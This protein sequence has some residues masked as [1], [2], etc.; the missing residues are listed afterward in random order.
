M[1]FE[2][3]SI[4][5]E[6]RIKRTIEIYIFTLLVLGRLFICSICLWLSSNSFN[7]CTHLFAISSMSSVSET[8]SAQYLHR[9][10]ASSPTLTDR[11]ITNSEINDT[12]NSTVG[13][14]KKNTNSRHVL[15]KSKRD[16]TLVE[17]SCKQKQIKYVDL[18]GYVPNAQTIPYCNSMNNEIVLC[19]YH[20]H[21]HACS[22]N[23]CIHLSMYSRIL[24][25]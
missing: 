13:I 24:L 22:K 14:P 2:K 8:S 23:L 19:Y 18:S 5:I 10:F 15:F 1:L 17:S 4:E 21:G 3:Y 20:H 7:C 12:T 16:I 6:N 9:I 11:V 25:N